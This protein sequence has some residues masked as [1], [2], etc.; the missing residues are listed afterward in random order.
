MLDILQ[1]FITK[2]GYGF[3][4]IDGG[5][6]VKRRYNVVKNFNTNPSCFILLVS[7]KAGKN[8]QINNAS[9]QYL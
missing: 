7:T 3:D 9:I 1:Q 4:R 5:T 2:Q 6:N 8:K